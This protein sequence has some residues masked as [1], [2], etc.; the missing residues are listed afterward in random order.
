M[1]SLVASKELLDCIG[2]AQVALHKRDVVSRRPCQ[3]FQ[4]HQGHLTGIVKVVH[5]LANEK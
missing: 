2:V 5:N 3:L 1:S 4:A